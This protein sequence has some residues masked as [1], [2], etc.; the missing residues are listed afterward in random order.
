MGGQTKLTAKENL[1]QTVKYFCFAVSAGMVQLGSFTLMERLNTFSFLENPYW[2]RYLIALALS[3]LW[4]FTFN[5]K[6]TFKSANN[7]P[8]AM[9]KVFI[10]YLVFIP[11]STWWGDA[12]TTRYSHLEW[13][14]YAVLLGTMLSNCVTEF[15]YQR[16]FVFGKSIN[17]NA[18]AKKRQEEQQH[19][20]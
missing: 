19:D 20:L 14:Q 4:N 2:P 11:P 9:L 18:A 12:I 7:I 17:T 1:T 13:V 3:V 10:Y 16:F 5:R 6:F 8:I 15:L